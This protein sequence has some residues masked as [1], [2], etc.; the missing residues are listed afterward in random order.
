MSAGMKRKVLEQN[1]ERQIWQTYRDTI[2]EQ[3]DF[4]DISARHDG[5]GMRKPSMIR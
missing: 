5:K 2:E 1:T 3:E 4:Q